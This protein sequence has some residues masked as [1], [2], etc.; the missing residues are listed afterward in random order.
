MS[1]PTSSHLV[2]DVVNSEEYTDE[3][4]LGERAVRHLVTNLE[5]MRLVD[6]WIES[7]GQEG[8]VDQIETTFDPKW[9]RERVEGYLETVDGVEPADL[10]AE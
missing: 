3:Y 1:F 6:T 10:L 8:R 5:T 7:Q 2:A 4:R 9:M